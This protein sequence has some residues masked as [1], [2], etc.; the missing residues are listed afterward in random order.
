[1]LRCL[2]SRWGLPQIS[3]QQYSVDETLELAV[4]V[5]RALY[6]LADVLV[7]KYLGAYLQPGFVAFSVHGFNSP[8]LV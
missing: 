5:G 8:R 6:R 2:R 7:S 1:M 4:E 3:P